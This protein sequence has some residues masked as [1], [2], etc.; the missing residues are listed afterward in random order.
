MLPLCRLRNIRLH[1]GV[2]TTPHWL[3]N[4]CVSA[5]IRYPLLLLRAA[6][7]ASTAAW[8]A[9]GLDAARSGP[10]DS[11]AVK[12]ACASPVVLAPRNHIPSSHAD[13]TSLLRSISS[14][15]P[16]TSLYRCCAT[17]A[18]AHR[19]YAQA[20]RCHPDLNGATAD[21][22]LRFQQL[23]AALAEILSEIAGNAV[24]G[25]AD[26]ASSR[27]IVDAEGAEADFARSW[28]DLVNSESF[29]IAGYTLLWVGPAAASPHL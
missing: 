25:S 4:G 20:K 6:A 15:C 10:Y 29:A 23:S 26:A 1:S 7:A 13:C 21:N 9:L 28:F 3:A 11:R 27:T 19:Y 22:T 16:Q 12:Q 2:L 18:T 14:E 8:S 24:A 17:A 5:P